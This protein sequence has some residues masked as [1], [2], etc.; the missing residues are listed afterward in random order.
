MLSITVRKNI[1]D[2]GLACKVAVHEDGTIRLL[3]SDTLL[4]E[5]KE[6]MDASKQTE[7]FNALRNNF[8]MD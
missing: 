5:N 7:A 2:A 1:F 6:L 4:R 8:S 3:R